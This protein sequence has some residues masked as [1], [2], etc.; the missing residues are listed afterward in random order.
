MGPTIPH[1]RL[2]VSVSSITSLPN[3]Q[4]G[5]LSIGALTSSEVFSGLCYIR[6]ECCSYVTCTN[7]NIAI[8]TSQWFVVITWL[9]HWWYNTS[10]AG[11]T[12]TITHGWCWWHLLWVTKS[13]LLQGDDKIVINFSVE[14]VCQL[15][16]SVL[17]FQQANHTDMKLSAS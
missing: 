9:R 15:A 12:K 5:K 6:L 11:V 4:L 17:H 3:V 10:C 2:R 8:V 1:P 16:F 7:N 14:A 13:D